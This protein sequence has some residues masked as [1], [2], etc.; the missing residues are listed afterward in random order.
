MTLT[1]QQPRRGPT[2]AWTGTVGLR[3]V[4]SRW[5]PLFPPESYVSLAQL[6]E[7]VVEWAFG[8][9]VPPGSVRWSAVSDVT[10]F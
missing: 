4:S 10:W 3:P 7:V 1:A 5:A 6:R 9:V 2:S 8:E